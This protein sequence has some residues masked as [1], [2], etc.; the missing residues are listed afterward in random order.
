MYIYEQK[1]KLK[2]EGNHSILRENCFI[3]QRK[4]TR[5]VPDNFKKK[6][7]NIASMINWITPIFLK[8]YFGVKNYNCS[9]KKCVPGDNS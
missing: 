4:T 9:E 2:F 3:K 7:R 5:I 8:I 1:K 6:K